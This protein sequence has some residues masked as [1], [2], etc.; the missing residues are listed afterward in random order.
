MRLP[1]WRLTNSSPSPLCSLSLLSVRVV[2]LDWS[3]PSRP[4]G[5]ML[6]YEILRRT[7]RSCAPGSAVIMS[8]LGDGSLDGLGSRCSYLE[9][10]ATHSVCGT[11]CFHTDTQ[12]I[13]FWSFHTIV[14]ISVKFSTFSRAFSLWFVLNLFHVL[15][16][17]DLWL[18]LAN[19][20]LSLTLS[21]PHKH[22]HTH[23]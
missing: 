4:N 16:V 3:H 23:T 18:L 12:V 14:C 20:I 11:S 15:D 6:G 7:Q 8:S 10:P 21:L 1:V 19:R 17:Q 22:T 2:R 9:C 5:I 13:L